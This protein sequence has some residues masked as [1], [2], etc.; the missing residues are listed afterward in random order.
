MK[1]LLYFGKINKIKK[2]G[3]G[4]ALKHQM[5]AL[6][7]QGIEYTLDP[8]DTF[9]IA[10]INTYWPDSKKL[11]KKL[12]EKNIP[13]IMHGHSTIEDFKNS[14]RFW[15]LIAK[16]WYN[17]NLLWFYKNA[18]LIITPT[19]YSKKCIDNYNLG[20]KVIAIS[21]GINPKE[22]EYNKEN[23]RA[24]KHKFHLNDDD[25]VVIGVGFP[26]NRK[27]IK[28]FFEIARELPYVKFFW[29]GHLQKILTE[30]N[31]LKAIRHKPHN[32]IMPG[33]ID[34]HIIKGAYHFA[35][36][37]VF[38]SYE[39]TEGIVVLESLASRCPTLIRDIGVY[40]D[41]MIH[42]KNCLKAHN[43]REFI[44]NIKY[45]LSN[46]NTEMLNEGYKLVNQRTIDDIGKDLKQAYL[47]VLKKN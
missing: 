7:S 26:F 15:K 10:H 43:N 32:V 20:T 45:V 14:F 29:F 36:A 27:G 42:K 18:D 46:D 9:D 5:L 21:N 1:V 33:Y 3:I 28:D 4:R 30:H 2:S 24:F 12:K 6:E 13:V 35:K 37:F 8:S 23:V 44:S 41:W 34:G 40:E 31:V 47:S 38:K 11:F 19:P 39:E 25:K 17:K 16:I 22:Y